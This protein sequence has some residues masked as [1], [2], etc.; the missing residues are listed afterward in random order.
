M[1]WIPTGRV[2]N[3]NIV[4]RFYNKGYTFDS[5]Y[6]ETRFVLR[7]TQDYK[8]LKF[9]AQFAR[10]DTVVIVDPVRV[11]CGGGFISYR[12]FDG[13]PFKRCWFSTAGQSGSTVA[14]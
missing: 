9:A 4:V 6:R 12:A 8:V 14:E 7:A 2:T 11:G 10:K 3:Y 13:D 5:G 1:R